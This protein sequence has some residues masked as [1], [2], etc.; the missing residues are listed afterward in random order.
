[1]FESSVK[2]PHLQTNH[3]HLTTRK[4]FYVEISRARHKAELVTDDAKALHDQ[5]EAVIGERIAAL[6]A[7][8]PAVD[9]RGQGRREI[10]RTV[11]RP[12]ADLGRDTAKVPR[13]PRN[14]LTGKRN[15]RRSASSRWRC[16]FEQPSPPIDS[17]FIRDTTPNCVNKNKF[18]LE[19]TQ[20]AKSESSLHRFSLLAAL[21]QVVYPNWREH[22]QINFSFSR[23]NSFRFCKQFALTVSI[24]TGRVFIFKI[25]TFVWLERIKP[26]Q[27]S[28]SKVEIHFRTG[29]TPI[30][31]EFAL[32]MPFHRKGKWFVA[33]GMD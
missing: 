30:V 27:N 25:D 22:T 31:E 6:E 3:S 4:R 28:I 32:P 1:M 26:P 2:L 10:E 7:V 16:S 11:D 15:W 33:D 19:N 20:I 5:L 23:H 9:S 18:L 24:G 14:R 17:R 8:E 13:R 29:F 21:Y 12:D